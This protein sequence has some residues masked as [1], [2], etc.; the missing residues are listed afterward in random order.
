MHIYDLPTG[1]PLSNDYLVVDNGT[2]H[3]KVQF[4]QF[5]AGENNVTFGSNDESTPST[6][7]DTGVLPDSGTLAMLFNRVSKMFSN[8]NY[9]R[10]LIGTI[11]MGTINTTIT[12]A[13][14]EIMETIGSVSM[15]TTARTLTGAIK[16]HSTALTQANLT[17][18]LAGLLSRGSVSDLN[19]ATAVGVYTY[20]S[21]ATNRP[22]DASGSLLVMRQTTSYVYQL[23]FISSATSTVAPRIFIRRTYDEN[24]WQDWYRITITTTSS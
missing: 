2:S 7:K 12:G 17:D 11:N 8:V 18:K 19:T 23:A 5:E 1:S 20:S 4:S 13:I 10:N 22:T 15:G 14:K 3:R 21:N 24:V 6:W 16:E 9:L